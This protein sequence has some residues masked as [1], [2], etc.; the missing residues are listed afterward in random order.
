MKN[1]FNNK[2]RYS[3]IEYLITFEPETIKM[4]CGNH[5]IEIKPNES[6]SYFITKHFKKDKFSFVEYDDELKTLIIED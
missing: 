2:I 5:C 4:L 3:L 6:G 1:E